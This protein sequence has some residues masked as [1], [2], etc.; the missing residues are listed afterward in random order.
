LVVN[1]GGDQLL[2]GAGLAFDADGCA[3]VDHLLELCEHRLHRGRVADDVVELDLLI[4]AL[5]VDV[6][7]ACLFFGDAQALH[8]CGVVDRER[9]LTGEQERDLEVVLAEHADRGAVVG[10]DETDDVVAAPQ[11]D[12]E[13]GEDR[14]A[15]DRFGGQRLERVGGEDGRA[16]AEDAAKH[17]ARRADGV[18]GGTWEILLAR[19]TFARYREGE[20][21]LVVSERSRI[22]TWSHARARTW[23]RR[24]PR[25]P[26]RARG[27]RRA[28]AAPCRRGV[29]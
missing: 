13:D 29:R 17:G 24:S 25:S 9:G 27:A 7:A 16:V 12:C 15:E 1:G 11:R 5:E 23:R 2:A 10:L 18:G 4:F 26:R 19:R 22:A 3:R 20:A 28:V 21:I 8:E 14:T 6:L